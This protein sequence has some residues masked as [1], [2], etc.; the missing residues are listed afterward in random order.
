MIEIE[1][2]SRKE[3]LKRKEVPLIILQAQ[4]KAHLGTANQQEKDG[5]Q[6][7]HPVHQIYQKKFKEIR[8]T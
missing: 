5:D 3:K 6:V 7:N 1:N 4:P 2:Y 8:H